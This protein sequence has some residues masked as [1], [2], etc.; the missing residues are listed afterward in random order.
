MKNQ[1][2]LFVLVIEKS[3][4]RL[5]AFVLS[6]DLKDLDPDQC[7]AMGGLILKKSE[8]FQA[9]YP[10]SYYDVILGKGPEMNNIADSFSPVTGWDQVTIETLTI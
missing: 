4:N 3:N 2:F 1:G 5:K 8:D 9:V 6:P 7:D 10:E